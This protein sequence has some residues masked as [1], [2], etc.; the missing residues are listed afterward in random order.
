MLYFIDTAGTDENF[1]PASIC[2]RIAVIDGTSIKIFF[3]NSGDEADHSV[4]LTCGEPETV[5]LRLAQEIGNQTVTG[6]G[7]LTIKANTAP[8]TDVSVVAFSAG[9]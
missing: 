9:A 6:G 2:S 5:A 1:F 7:V 8:F 4:D 3:T